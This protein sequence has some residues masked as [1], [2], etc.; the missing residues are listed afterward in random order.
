MFWLAMGIIAFCAVGILVC[1][2]YILYQLKKEDKMQ[3]Q[4]KNVQKIAVIQRRYSLPDEEP[5]KELNEV[6]S[7]E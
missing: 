6:R 2:L 1:L 3:R 4:Q 5:F 7:K